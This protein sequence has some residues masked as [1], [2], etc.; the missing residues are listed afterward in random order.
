METRIN[1]NSVLGTDKQTSLT[2]LLNILEKTCQNCNPLTPITCVTGCKTWKLKNQFRKLREKTENPNF[3]TKLLNTLKN[4]RRLQ[5]LEL[6]SKK[7]S[8][9]MHIQQRLKKLGFDHSR[10]T[11]IREY[12]NPLTEAGL[13]GQDHNLYYAT[14]FG[15]KISELVKKLP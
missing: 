9:I 3:R 15:C 5:I 8:S 12:I 2:D 10:Q 7:H 13:A 6:I 11:I 1:A 4:K 14:V